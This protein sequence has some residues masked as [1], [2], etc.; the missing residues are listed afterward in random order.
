VLGMDHDHHHH[1]SSESELAIDRHLDSVV[2]TNLFA[3]QPPYLNSFFRFQLGSNTFD[4]VCPRAPPLLGAPCPG[5][6]AP[7]I[8]PAGLLFVLLRSPSPLAPRQ[9][10]AAAARKRTRSACRRLSHST[11]RNRTSHG[12]GYEFAMEAWKRVASVGATTINTNAGVCFC[13]VACEKAGKKNPLDGG[14][15]PVCYCV[16]FEWECMTCEVQLQCVRD[17]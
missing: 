3:E 16:G 4:G 10:G 8:S 5:L 14:A 13:W 1:A 17:A 2:V 11:V 12:A 6:P 7:P 15:P 9:L